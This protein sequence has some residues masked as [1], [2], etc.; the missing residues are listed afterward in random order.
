MAQGIT[1]LCGENMLLIL[2]V[3]ADARRQPNR[4]KKPISLRGICEFQVGS[5][6]LECPNCGRLLLKPHNE[7]WQSWYFPEAGLNPG[8]DK[9]K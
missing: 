2:I 1:C 6:I 5:N 7:D 4:Y 3:N 9:R 8:W